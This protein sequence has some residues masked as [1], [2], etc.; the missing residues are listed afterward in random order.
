MKRWTGLVAG[1]LLAVSAFA[2]QDVQ[3]S[4]AWVR[5]TAPGQDSAAVS[6]SI[7]SRQ[8]ARLVAVESP[9]AS[10][11][12]IH[13]MKHEGGMMMMR[14]VEALPLPA[15]RTVSLGAG[16]HL[17]LVGLKRPLK[18]GDSVPLKLTVEFADK[19]RQTVEVNAEVRPFGASHDMHGRDDMDGMDM[20][21]QHQHGH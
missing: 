3:V 7:G 9:A 17:M 2:A 11:A 12:E 18:A 16:D 19:R 13:V 1:M 4:D 21:H 20:P 5:A 6:L 14:A 10:G 15:Q 8:E